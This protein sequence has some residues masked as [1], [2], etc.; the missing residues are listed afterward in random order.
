MLGASDHDGFADRTEAGRRLADRL[1]RF[2]NQQ[3][4]VLALPRGGVPVAYEVARALASPLDLVLVRKIGAPHQPEL[5]IG[6]VVDGER[7]ELVVNRDLMEACG[8]PASYLESER[9][10]QIEEIE[11]R[12][13]RYL[14]GRRRVPVEGRTAILVDDGIATGATM[15]AALR[16]TRRGRPRR[17]VL[18]VPVAAPDTIERLRPGVDEVVCLLMP[19]ALGAIGSFYRDFRQ[20]DDQEVVRLLERAAQWTSASTRTPARSGG[21]DLDQER[22]S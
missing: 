7:P 11:R 4:V 10:R 6:A 21:D 9:R 13:E 22:G 15:E 3:P 18:A 1:S 16:A 12:R 5:A 20:L 17:L 19:A 8:I 2:R 14:A